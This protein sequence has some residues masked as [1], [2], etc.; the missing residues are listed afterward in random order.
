MYSF[1][2]YVT[3]CEETVIDGVGFKVYRVCSGFVGEDQDVFIM[4][5]RTSLARRW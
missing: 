5:S 4:G 3:N 1:V 2:S